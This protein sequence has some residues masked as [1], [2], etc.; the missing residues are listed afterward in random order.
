MCH[1]D[2]VSIRSQKGL[3]TV[4]TQ[5]TWDNDVQILSVFAGW[6]RNVRIG[7]RSEGRG[8]PHE[9]SWEAEDTK[10]P[11]HYVQLFQL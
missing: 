2:H 5:I 6:F 11:H 10:W 7:R 4:E 8:N 3:F 9:D 1:L